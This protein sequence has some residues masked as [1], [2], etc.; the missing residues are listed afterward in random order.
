MKIVDLDRIH[1]I[2]NVDRN[3]HKIV[4]C[5]GVFDLLHIGHIKY[6]EE[7][8]TFGDILVVTLTPDRFVN[9]GPMRPVFP[10]Q[11][12]AEAI[13][14]LEVVDFVCINQLPDAI[15]TIELIKPDYYVKGSD[16]KNYSDD[17][18][19]MIEKEANAVHFNGGQIIF[20]S[21]I[22]FSSST[23][24]NNH[25]STLNDEQFAFI[26]NLKKNYS[27]EDIKDF[28]IKLN[29]LKVLVIGETIIDEYV[30]CDTVGKSG[31]EPVLVNKKLSSEKYA[32]GVIAVANH[33]SAFSNKVDVL[34]YIGD[35]DDHLTFI[36]KNINSNVT[37]KYIIKQNSPTI[38]K[39]RFL[40]KY[41]NT[42]IAAI[43]DINDSF[44]NEIEEKDFCMKLEEKI[45]SYDLILSVDYGHGLITPK[46]VT[47]LQDKSKYLVA[48]TQ[49]NSFNSD[50]HVISKY[51]NLNSVCVH[52]GELR[53]NYRD[54]HTSVKELAQKLYESLKLESIIITRGN[55]GSLGY[56]NGEYVNCPAFANKIVDRVGAGDTFLA[57]VSLCLSCNIP[58]DLSLFL[59]NLAGAQ[60]V[61]NIGTGLKLDKISM[62]KTIDTLL[63]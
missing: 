36:E 2:I 21:D 57:I 9:K 49:L 7:A 20:T 56:S 12:R 29:N 14:A 50:Y 44:L 55:N 38:L 17:I 26:H 45:N 43:Y 31:K 1:T 39:T 11:L 19:G 47:L 6:F 32:G 15:K 51:N 16:Y 8:K 54:R 41:S 37:F 33:L 46:V 52:E 42:K 28:I 48:N 35:R 27:F 63:K 18:T 13:A 34:S 40:D 62:L 5:H 61:A 23:L 25:F 58:F 24:L 59:G 3:K 53:H 30:F 60:M 10:E 22:T 4:L